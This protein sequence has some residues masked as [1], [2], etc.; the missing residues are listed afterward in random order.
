MAHQIGHALGGLA[1]EQHP[2]LG[3][4]QRIEAYLNLVRAVQPPGL[5]MDERHVRP[6]GDH[7]PVVR[8]AM[9]AAYR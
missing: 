2:L 8:G 7:L 1:V 6:G 3:L 9:A 5:T 4:F